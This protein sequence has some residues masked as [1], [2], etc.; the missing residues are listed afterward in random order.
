ME[1]LGPFKGIY[2]LTK[3]VILVILGFYRENGKEHGNY[4]NGAI[5][6]FGLGSGCFF[7]CSGA[8]VFWTLGFL[9]S[10]I[11]VWGLVC[12][13]FGIQGVFW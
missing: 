9:G 11:S 2:R 13:G 3:G 6:S 8:P 4:Y 5:K 12:A 1:T 7:G 10:R